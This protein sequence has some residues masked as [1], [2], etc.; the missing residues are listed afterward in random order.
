MS[1][2]DYTKMLQ[3]GADRTL[4]DNKILKCISKDGSEPTLY[5]VEALYARGLGIRESCMRA[6]LTGIY[7]NWTMWQPISGEQ[8]A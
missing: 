4:E 1:L 2:L 5:H 3:N 8:E 6:D 7:M